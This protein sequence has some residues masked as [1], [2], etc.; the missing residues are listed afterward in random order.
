MSRRKNKVL[1]KVWDLDGEEHMVT[2]I[3]A[4]DMINHNKWTGHNPTQVPRDL[5]IEKY[6]NSPK[7][8]NV[9]ADDPIASQVPIDET[10]AQDVID[11]AGNAPVE[12]ETAEVDLSAFETKDELAAYAKDKFAV[13]LDMRKSLTSLQDEVND[14]EDEIS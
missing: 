1:V 3:N 14:L 4:R 12:H 2:P 5:E 7:G 11:N 6:R 9:D 10:N 8:V 13:V